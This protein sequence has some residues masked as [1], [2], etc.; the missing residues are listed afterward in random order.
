MR[1][2]HGSIAVMM[3]IGLLSGCGL[4]IHDPSLQQSAEATRTLVTEADLS[5][6]INGQLTGAADLAKRQEAAIVNFYVM[7]RNQQFLQ[8]LQPDVLE[9]TA[10]SGDES[11]A[12]YLKSGSGFVRNPADFRA[13]LAQAI[14]CRLDALL[15]APSCGIDPITLLPTPTPVRDWKT[16]TTLRNTSFP[17]IQFTNTEGLERNVQTKL[18]LLRAAIGKKAADN[19][20][21][22]E[23][24]RGELACADITEEQRAAADALDVN[25]SEE[26]ERRFSAYVIACRSAERGRRQADPIL[27]GGPNS[28]LTQVVLEVASLLK[29]REAQQREGIRLA[30]EMKAL[31]KQIADAQG[32]GPAQA[33]LN[34]LLE[35][36]QKALKGANGAA[37]LAGLRELGDQTDALLQIELTNS[38]ADAAGTPAETPAAEGAVT[39]QGQALV[40]LA[41]AGAAA[42]DAYRD[43][44]P[45]AR[46]QALIVARVAL[47]QQIEVAAL[48]AALVE[49]RLRLLIAKRDFMVN[50][51]HQLAEAGLFL[52]RSELGSNQNKLALTRLAA[53]W[54]AGQIEEHAITYR[55]FAAKRETSI[56]ISAS[57]A[58]NIQ[59]A[60]LAATDQIVAYSKGGLTK[61]MIADT[62]AKLFIGGALL[63]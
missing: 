46:A 11:N 18:S 28:E 62:F 44:A 41:S 23:D 52:Q 1:Q 25:V 34:D 48:E 9:Q 58:R 54:D 3:L 37:K 6:Q 8:L 55:V 61:E 51:V 12:S 56:R 47:T 40:K 42:A 19:P 49:T 22:P 21:L 45:A 38:A 30:A 14:N 13:D 31:L 57:N 35:K 29:E 60:V 4:Y 10:F 15:A 20:D 32:P 26:V 53:S 39:A 5:T 7:R 24:L 16:L 43:E 17:Q 33:G 27:Q 63:K 2:A 59:A 50:E 36:V